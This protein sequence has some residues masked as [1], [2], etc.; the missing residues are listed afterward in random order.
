MAESRVVQSRVVQSRVVQSRVG[1]N[2]LPR[3]V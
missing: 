1:V 3:S 2:V